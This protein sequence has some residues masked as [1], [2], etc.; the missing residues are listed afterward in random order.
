MPALTPSDV[1]L[2]REA[3][4]EP[5]LV[6]VTA[7]CAVLTGEQVMEVQAALLEYLQV[8]YKTSHLNGTNEGLIT[9]PEAKRRLIRVNLRV[10]LGLPAYAFDV[11][12]NGYGYGYGSVAVPTVGVF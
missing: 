10:L 5:S 1:G 11:D 8:R 7:R 3:V 12:A 2:V 9:D 6:L 4:G